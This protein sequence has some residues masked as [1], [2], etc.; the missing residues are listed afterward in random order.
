MGIE[1]LLIELTPD[2]VIQTQIRVTDMEFLDR[3]NTFYGFF[4]YLVSSSL[5]VH[6]DQAALLMIVFKQHW[7][8][9]D[10]G[11]KHLVGNIRDELQAPDEKL[12]RNGTAIK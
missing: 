9:D 6:S 4:H 10:C 1:E 11:F 2:L 7:I 8:I 5:D 12:K 3:K